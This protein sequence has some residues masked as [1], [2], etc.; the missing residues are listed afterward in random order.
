MLAF[1]LL[2]ITNTVFSSA[3]RLG[4]ALTDAKT[5]NAIITS[6]YA[7]F[8]AT[9]VTF[10]LGVPL[11]YI[12]ARREFTGKQLVDAVIDL[13]ILIP[14]NAAG[15]ALLL[16]LGPKTLVGAG[17]SQVGLSFVDSLF[18]VVAAMTFV[19]SPFMIR[20]AEDTFKSVDPNIEKVARSLGASRFK[21]FIHV[22]FPLAFRGILTGCLLT[23]ARGVSEFG[24]VIVLAYY[25]KTAAVHLYEVF[26]NR[27]GENSPFVTSI[28]K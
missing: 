20:S 3:D 5:V 13:P 9:L 10:A 11:A 24:A 25:P 17:L 28:S 4:E 15:I 14:H 2:P 26:V 16:L 23:W 21:A 12:L 22:T 1:L 18:G 19:S 8:L 6:F 7:A 27:N